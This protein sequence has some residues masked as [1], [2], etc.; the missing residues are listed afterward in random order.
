LPAAEKQ[1]VVASDI[2]LATYNG[3]FGLLFVLIGAIW[4]GFVTWRVSRRP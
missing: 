2:A 3:A 1:R 4:V